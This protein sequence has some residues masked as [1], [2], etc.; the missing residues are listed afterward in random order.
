MANVYIPPEIQE[1]VFSYLMH[2]SAK[3]LAF[4]WQIQESWFK[5]SFQRLQRALATNSRETYHRVLV[6]LFQDIDQLPN[7]TDETRI[8]FHKEITGLHFAYMFD[9]NSSRLWRI[10]WPFF[11][12]LTIDQLLHLNVNEHFMTGY[13]SEGGIYSGYLLLN[14]EMHE[15][16]VMDL[17]SPSLSWFNKLGSHLSNIF[18]QPANELS[19]HWSRFDDLRRGGDRGTVSFGNWQLFEKQAGEK[20]TLQYSTQYS[21]NILIY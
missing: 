21:I 14:R 10:I 6:Q 13:I 16:E 9:L 20:I 3:G 8:K 12:E 4:K 7:L 5:V 17:L 15:N 2:S 1:N 11:H 19:L 18:I